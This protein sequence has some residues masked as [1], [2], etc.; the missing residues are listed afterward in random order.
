MRAEVRVHILI[1]GC[2]AGDD[3]RPYLHASADPVPQGYAGAPLTGILIGELLQRGHRVTGLTTD[4]SLPLAAGSVSLDG[5]GFRFVACPARRRAWRFNGH[6]LGRAVDQFALERRALAR[7]IAAAAPDIVHAHWSYEFALAALDQTAPHLITCH[8]SPA[9]VLRH[10]R[11]AYRTVRYLMARQVFRRGREFSAVS[12]YLARALT[13]AIGHLPEVVPNPV[14]PKVLALG[15]VRPRGS[16]RRV[17]MICNGWGARKNPEPALRAF[18]RWRHDIPTAELHLFGDGFGP[19]GIAQRW[20]EAHGVAQGL[21][22]HGRLPHAELLTALAGMD[23]L[24]HPALEESFGVVLAEA[25]GLGLPVIAGRDSGA[26]PWVVGAGATG[27]S[28]CG[29]LTD[30]RSDVALARALADVFDE[31]YEVRS[32]AGISRVKALF[33]AQGVA[34]QYLRRYAEVRAKWSAGEL[35][36]CDR[37]SQVE[38]QSDA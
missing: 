36:P 20:A 22:L 23:V 26:V 2:I 19:A 3:V 24:L 4:A 16:T 38:K 29:V 17:A 32:A 33:S 10:A 7:A 34:T 30:V 27:V 37:H 18:A 31:H 15:C 6:H 1:A 5:P 14:S 11:N 8:D 28:D 12:D 25:M 35:A 21:R 13:P 9:V